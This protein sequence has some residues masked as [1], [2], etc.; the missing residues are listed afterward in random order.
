[1][2]NV[3]IIAV[4]K[5]KE[6]WMQQGCAE[7]SKRLQGWC[8]CT[9]TEID[10]YRLADN[11]TPAQIAECLEKEGERILA[12]IPRGALVIAMCIE[13]RQL[14]SEGLAQYIQDTALMGNSSLTFVI[15]GSYGL[16]PQVKQRAA[17]RLSISP[18]TFPHQLARVLLFEQIYRAFSINANAKYHK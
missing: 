8:D 13:G 17:L 16:S 7:Y 15:G 11:P 18:M 4:G 12:K 14:S 10:E 2:R 5:L 9:V 6:R 1:M 3:G